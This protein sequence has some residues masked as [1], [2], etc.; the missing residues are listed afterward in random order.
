MH[1]II[2]APTPVKPSYHSL[3]CPN[4]RCIIAQ[5]VLIWP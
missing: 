4:N 3:F 1:L 2:Y 5:M